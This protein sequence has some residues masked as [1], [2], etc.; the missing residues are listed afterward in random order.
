[1]D[2]GR[3]AKLPV[4]YDICM[5][6]PSVVSIKWKKVLPGL[7]FLVVS[8]IIVLMLPDQDD[9]FLSQTEEK[10]DYQEVKIREEGTVVRVVDGDTI[11]V[12]VEG[13]K[14]KVRLIGIDTPESQDP[15]KE[16]EC[17]AEEASSRLKALIG[18][19]MVFLEADA[20]QGDTDAYGRLLRYVFIDKMNVNQR[21]LEEGYAYEYTYDLPY[22]YQ[23]VFRVAEKQAREDGLG[24]WSPQTCAGRRTDTSQEQPPQR[25]VQQEWKELT[26]YQCNCEKS[27]DDTLTCDEARYLLN[28]CGCINIDG[29][30]DGIPCERG[31]C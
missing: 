21:L 22:R 4:V 11:H 30:S 18:G 10:R 12:L 29:D 31:P 14:K 5:I 3:P 9:F 8:L 28:E 7:G 20:S 17:F 6:F 23:S 26:P 1:V 13:K 19:E 27:C 2:G 24:L 25:V 15:R 16:V